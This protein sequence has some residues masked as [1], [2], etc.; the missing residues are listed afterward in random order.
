MNNILDHKGYSGSVEFSAEDQ[1]FFGKVLGI[2]DVVTFEG[3]SV[4]EITKSF[5][6][7]VDDYIKSCK[8]S[9]KDPDV[10]F[11]GSFNVRIK[12]AI[13]RLIS[14][15]AQ[16]AKISLNRYVESILEKEVLGEYP[17]DQ[18]ELNIAHEAESKY[19]SRKI[20]KRRKQK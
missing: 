13:H 11:K 5:R 7:A 19:G 6:T 17:A 10:A 16:A 9:G 2:R 20:T 15:R 1:V 12:P 8:E 3:K 18:T 4:H 14:Q